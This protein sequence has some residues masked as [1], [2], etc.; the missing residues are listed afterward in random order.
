M[1]RLFSLMVVM[2][3]AS[4][5][6]QEIGTEIPPEQVQQDPAPTPPPTSYDNPYSQPVQAPATTTQGTA[7]AADPAEA[8]VGGGTP[9]PRA[10]AFGVRASF[11]GGTIPIAPATSAQ[12]AAAVPTLGLTFMAT[13]GMALNFD[14]GLGLGIGSNF[15]YGFGLGVGVNAYLGSAAK[16]IRPFVTG[17][18]AFG[19]QLSRASDDFALSISAGGGAEYWFSDYF[20]LNGQLLVGVPL[21]LKQM[22]VISIGTFQPGIGA[23]F[24]F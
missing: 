24:Y 2:A 1:K 12:P 13:D 7:N 10:G 17:N 3:W 11:N 6:A 19:K 18:V 5:S 4:A 15:S 22:N 21:N 20:S 9:G 23:T 16:P 14:V 8:S